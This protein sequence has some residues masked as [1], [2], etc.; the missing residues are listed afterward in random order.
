MLGREVVVVEAA[1][2]PVGRG[3]PE[4]G[5]FRNVHPN[6]LLGACYEAVLERSGAAGERMISGFLENACQ[7]SGDGAMWTLG[8]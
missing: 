4:K 8:L 7:G 5:I 6:E 2:T 1:R 3:H